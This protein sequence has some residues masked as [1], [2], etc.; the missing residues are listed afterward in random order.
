MLTAT[1]K[2]E[3]ASI[4]H[5]TYTKDSVAYLVKSERIKPENIFYMNTLKEIVPDFDSGDEQ[6]VSW[7]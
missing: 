1:I 6:W 3:R 4:I 7:E 5:S 2:L